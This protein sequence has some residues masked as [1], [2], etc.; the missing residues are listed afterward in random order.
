ME[1]K[2][3]KKHCEGATLEWTIYGEY[4]TNCITDFGD[5]LC[6]VNDVTIDPSANHIR[7]SVYKDYVEL[8]EIEHISAYDYY[9]ALS[10]I[11]VAEALYTKAD[12]LL[13]MLV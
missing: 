9:Y 8:D 3:F 4:D 12:E 13:K 11:E 5:I 2:Y 6:V 10:Q 1:K 7:H